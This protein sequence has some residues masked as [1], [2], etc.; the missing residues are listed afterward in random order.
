V[1]LGRVPELAAT[2]QRALDVAF[3]A[4]PERFVRGHPCVRLPPA[5]VTINPIDPGAPLQTADVLLRAADVA[6]ASAER[7]PSTPPMPILSGT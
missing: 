3:A 1:F 2:R 7:A 5:K 6:P 4:H